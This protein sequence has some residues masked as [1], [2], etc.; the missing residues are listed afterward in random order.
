M[1]QQASGSWWSVGGAIVALI[2]GHL[3]L[4]YGIQTAHPVKL[5][6]CVYHHSRDR[7]LCLSGF[8][9]SAMG[10]FFT[11]PGAFVRRP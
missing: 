9:Y 5:A 8:K 10:E 1:A 4:K 6:I 11:S 3:A 2:A 7:D